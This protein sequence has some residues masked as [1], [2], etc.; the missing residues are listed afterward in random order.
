LLVN[1]VNARHVRAASQSPTIFLTAARER[2]TE[3]RHAMVEDAVAGVQ[4]AKTG[5]IGGQR[6]SQ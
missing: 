5:G 6:K 2:G 1:Y 4:A 3:Q